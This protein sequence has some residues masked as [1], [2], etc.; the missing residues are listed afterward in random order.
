MLR[1][2]VYTL[3]EVANLLGLNRAIVRRW[4]KTGEFNIQC[5]GSVVFIPKWEVELIKEKGAK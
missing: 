2:Y 5:V 3:A 4:I 1:E